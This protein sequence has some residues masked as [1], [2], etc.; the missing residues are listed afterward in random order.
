M[1]M[2]TFVS[3]NLFILIRYFISLTYQW[4]YRLPHT[5]RKS[6]GEMIVAMLQGNPEKRPTVNDCLEMPFMKNHYIPKSLPISCLSCEP[7]FDQLEGAGDIGYNR[8]PLH[9]LNDNNNQGKT[10]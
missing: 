2:F 4:G 10:G 9:E 8:Q 3:M 7:R 1:A 6:S 5:L